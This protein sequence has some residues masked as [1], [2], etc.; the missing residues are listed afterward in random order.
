MNLD[1]VL[2]GSFIR[3]NGIPRRVARSVL[4]TFNVEKIFIFEVKDIESK[5]L[6]TFNID[7]KTAEFAFKEYKEKHKNTI[8]LHRNKL[9]NTLYTINSLN[10]IVE[11]QTGRPDKDFKVNWEV[12][13]NSLLLLKQDGNLDVL[14]TRL[15]EVIDNKVKESKENASN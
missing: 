7:K 15:C 13:R 4:E 14:K 12:Y 11:L 10:K 9:T 1:T 3:S 2:V 6:I 8:Q 5:F